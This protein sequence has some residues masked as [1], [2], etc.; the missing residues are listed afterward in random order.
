MKRSMG[1][2]AGRISKEL[3][4]KG[5]RFEI[6]YQLSAQKTQERNDVACN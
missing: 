4:K 3:Q 6:A 5:V 1:K 2:S